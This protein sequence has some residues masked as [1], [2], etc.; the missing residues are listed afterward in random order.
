MTH[1]TSE[2]SVT[3]LLHFSLTIHPDESWTASWVSQ[4]GSSIAQATLA[5]LLAMSTAKLL[6]APSRRVISESE[7]E[8]VKLRAEKYKE[9]SRLPEGWEPTLDGCSVTICGPAQSFTKP[10]RRITDGVTHE[11]PVADQDG[12]TT[13]DTVGVLRAFDAANPV[14][15]VT[16][17]TA[18]D[19]LLPGATQG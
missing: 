6:E 18:S 8:L 13:P 17:A 5:K 10:F 14:R 12:T 3:D 4:D 1:P 9:E 15:P 7:A 2:V 11:A 19:N 16:D